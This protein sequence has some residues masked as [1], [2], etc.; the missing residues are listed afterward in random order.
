MPKELNWESL[1]KKKWKS[2]GT[3]TRE[4]RTGGQIRDGNGNQFVC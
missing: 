3:R 1:R 2:I 4:T